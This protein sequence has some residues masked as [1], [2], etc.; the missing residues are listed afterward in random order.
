[1]YN[2]DVNDRDG[3]TY[4]NV[5]DDTWSIWSSWSD[6]SATV[7]L[8]YRERNRHC[9]RKQTRDRCLGHPIQFEKCL[10]FPEEYPVISLD[11][12]SAR[13]DGPQYVAG[14]GTLQLFVELIGKWVGV[15]SDLGQ[16]DFDDGNVACKH[17]GL[18][19]ATSVWTSSVMD[20]HGHFQCTVNCEGTEMTL[21]DCEINL[22]PAT[23]DVYAGITCLNDGEWDVWS[24]WSQNCNID[25]KQCRT[26]SCIDGSDNCPETSEQQRV[27][28]D[29]IKTYSIEC[30]TKADGSDY[31][32]KLSTTEHGKVCQKWTVQSP[33][34][35]DRT[36]A[37]YPNGGLGDHNYCRNPEPV[38]MPWCYTIDPAVRWQYC[39]IGDPMSTCGS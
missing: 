30:Y 33:H 25:H 20:T 26:R 18:P 32:G 13:L 14:N 5:V 29:L 17:L 11:K 9:V 21:N 39:D 35:H 16:W 10:T 31:R 15:N 19:G 2:Q 34:S 37:N 8:G 6:C 22:M 12:V 23:R 24:S 36:V 7:G 1:M 28:Y 27:I 38:V 3:A 4:G